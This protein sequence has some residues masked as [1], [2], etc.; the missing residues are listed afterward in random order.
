MVESQALDSLGWGLFIVLVGVGWYIGSVYEMDTGSYIALGVG[1]ILIGI[2]VI[3]AKQNIKINKF[4]IFFAIVI[5][6]IGT[7]GILGYALDLFLTIIIVIG[8]FVIEEALAKIL[9]NKNH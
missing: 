2:N 3:K 1:L 9:K 8:L 6:A 5:L 4:A 7:T